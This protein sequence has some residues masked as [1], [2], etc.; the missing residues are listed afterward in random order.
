MKPD[1]FIVIDIELPF[2]CNFD[3]FEIIYHN[4]YKGKITHGFIRNKLKLSDSVSL[5]LNGTFERWLFLLNKD[6]C[7]YSF[8]YNIQTALW[9]NAETKKWQYVS[10]FPNFIKRWCQ[11]CLGVLEYISSN[12]EKGEDILEH[13]DDPEE[14]LLCEDRLANAIKRLEFNCTKIKYEALL[15]SRYTQVFN[16]SLPVVNRKE[17]SNKRFPVLFSL[18]VTGSHFFG[19]HTG[20]LSLVNRIIRV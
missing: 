8:R 18:V 19:V 20:V 4:E 3:D 13:I 9:F 16:Q 7:L 14:I 5:K 15:N 2:K 17:I 1:T 12:V 10:I 6:D 11:P